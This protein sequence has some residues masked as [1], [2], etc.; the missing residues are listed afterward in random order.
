MRVVSRYSTNPGSALPSSTLRYEES[1]PSIASQPTACRERATG[2]SRHSGTPG[3][4]TAHTPPGTPHRKDG[5]RTAGSCPRPRTACKWNRASLSP[6]RDCP[7]ETARPSRRR[8]QA[9]RRQRF[10]QGVASSVRAV[11]RAVCAGGPAAA[12]FYFGSSST[13]AIRPYIS[14]IAPCVSSH[15]SACFSAPVKSVSKRPCSS[16]ACS[17]A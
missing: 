5:F 11:R 6:A 8:R 16:R 13:P 2:K 14:A 17:Q 10:W 1:A 4:R 9:R 7:T 15:F 3:R 12:G